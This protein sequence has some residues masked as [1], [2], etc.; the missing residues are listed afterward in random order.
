MVR[1]VDHLQ[2]AYPDAR[3]RL[4]RIA[5]A[6]IAADPEAMRGFLADL[7]AEHG[8][9]EGYIDDLGMAAA[10]PYLRANLLQP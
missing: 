8:S 4:V 5:P 6:M 9:I 10:V 7:R 3:E 2:R 1:F